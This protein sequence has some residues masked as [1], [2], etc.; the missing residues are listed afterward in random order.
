MHTKP[1]GI[2]YNLA[3]PAFLT[4]VEM[5]LMA[6]IRA[7]RSCVRSPEASGWCRCSLRTNRVNVIQL[8]ST[9][10]TLK[11]E[12]FA[13]LLFVQHVVCDIWSFVKPNCIFSLS[14]SWPSPVLL[15]H[16]KDCWLFLIFALQRAVAVL[17]KI[18]ESQYLIC[19]QN[20]SLDLFT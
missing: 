8:E 15:F 4:E 9:I 7:L 10:F 2:T 20:K 16:W 19:C 1:I 3:M 12:M 17:T 11:K 14:L 13:L 5:A 6:V 18:S